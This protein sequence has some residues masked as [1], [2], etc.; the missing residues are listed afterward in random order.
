MSVLTHFLIFNSLYRQL[1][2]EFTGLDWEVISS[3]MHLPDLPLELL[4]EIVSLLDGDLVLKLWLIGCTSLHSK[5]S[6]PRSARHLDFMLWTRSACSDQPF[7]PSYV[8]CLSGLESIYIETRRNDLYAGRASPLK[9]ASE[10]RMLGGGLKEIHLVDLSA[11]PP[12]LT[13]VRSKVHFDYHHWCTA[14][15]QGQTRFRNVT[16]LA[17]GGF[18]SSRKASIWV[19]QISRSFPIL[20]LPSTFA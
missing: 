14:M 5:L 6:L 9:D 8:T 3:V 11:L 17:L 13:C 2:K 7:L 16:T 18:C 12:S 4:G 1:L 15:Y 20:S 10:A 19:S